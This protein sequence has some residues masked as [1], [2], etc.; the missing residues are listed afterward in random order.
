M[1]LKITELKRIKGTVH[2]SQMQP[3][4]HEA[5]FAGMIP[6]KKSDNIGMFFDIPQYLGDNGY[7]FSVA[8]TLFADSNWGV[9]RWLVNALLKANGY[10]AIADNKA[11]PALPYY[12][13]DELKLLQ[14]Q[15]VL[16]RL[17]KKNNGYWEICSAKVKNKIADENLSKYE[18]EQDETKDDIPF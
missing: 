4:W 1:P 10:K 5:I 18:I 6:Y 7:T 9:E 13:E 8:K 2:Y 17:R 3:G 15:P 12:N 16:L 11:L 14:K